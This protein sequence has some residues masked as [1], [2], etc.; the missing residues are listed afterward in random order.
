MPQTDY[1]KTIIYKIVCNDLN[2]TGCYVG[3]TTNFR[4]RKS[5][6]KSSCYNE[7]DL[8]RF[9]LKIYKTIRQNGGWNNWSMIEIEKYFCVDKNEARARERYW[10]ENLN[11]SLN[12]DYPLR[13][14]QEYNKEHQ[15]QHTEYCK[16]YYKNNKEQFKKQTYQYFIENKDEIN[17]KRR[18]KRLLKKQQTQTND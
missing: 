8:T 16:N 2:I 11:S 15:Q 17:K 6:H 1:S 13:S 14:T 5:A 4:R 3:H 10:F 12:S 18:E 9:N 7:T